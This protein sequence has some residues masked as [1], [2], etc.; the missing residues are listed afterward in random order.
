[1]TGSFVKASQTLCEQGYF[2]NGD[3]LRRACSAAGSFGNI[4]G[5]TNSSCTDE[6]PMGY[7]CLPSVGNPIPC[8]AGTYG[9][10]VGLTTPACSGVCAKG[11]YCPTGS[12]SRTQMQCPVGRFGSVEGLKSDTC[13]E[14]CDGINANCEPTQCAPG[15]YCPLASMSAPLRSS[16]PLLL[17][18]LLVAS[19]M[20][21]S[22]NKQNK[23][24]RKP[25][26]K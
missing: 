5:L 7:Y 4:T 19:R 12:T 24:L 6:C 11:Y 15:Y 26:E 16:L 3:G 21:K 10:A 1:M 17:C 14:N 8:P 20:A 25:K 2:C 13:S 23:R 18:L 22:Q 9:G